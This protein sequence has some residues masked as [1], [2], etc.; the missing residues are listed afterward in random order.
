MRDL[1]MCNGESSDGKHSILSFQ[2]NPNSFCEDE[3]DDPWQRIETLMELVENMSM[4]IHVKALTF[5]AFDEI[6]QCRLF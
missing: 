4:K 3:R 6:H 1:C 5:L 2:Q